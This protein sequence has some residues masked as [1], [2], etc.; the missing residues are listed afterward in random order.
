MYK[1]FFYVCFLLLLLGC[2]KEKFTSESEWIA[3]IFETNLSLADLIPDSLTRYNPDSSLILVFEEE[4]GISSLE[5]ILEIP[6]KIE[7]LEVNLSSLVLDDR[8]FN[9]TITLAE[10]YP[11]SIL[12]NGRNAELDAQDIQA[13]EGTVI[14]VT[15]QFFTEATFVEGWIDIEISNDLPVEAELLEFELRNDDDKS[16]V[17]SGTFENLAPNS[18]TKDSFDLSGKTVDG[19]LELIVKRVKTKASDGEVKVDAFKGLRIDFRVR[20]LKPKEATAIFPSQNLVERK[21]ETEYEFGGGDLTQIEIKTGAMYMKVVSTIE[22]EIILNYSFLRSYKRGSGSNDYIQNEW[23]IPPAPKG[24]ESQL[25]E[26]FPV[27]GY[28]IYLWGE[29]NLELPYTNHIYNELIASIEY[30]GVERTLSLEDKITIEFGLIDL[31]PKK[32]FGDPG[33]HELSFTDSLEINALDKFK[34]QISLEDANLN[35]DF[36]NS[37]GIQSELKINSLK[38]VNNRIPQTVELQ[39]SE[40]M[41]SILIDKV[42]NDS[43]STPFEKSISIGKNNS[44]LKQFLENIPDQ[45]LPDIDVTVRPNGTYQLTDFAFDYSQLKLDVQ[46]EVPLTIGLDSLTLQSSSDVSLFENEEVSQIKKATFTLKVDNDF[47]IEMVATL[48]F[49]DENGDVLLEG[50]DGVDNV[51]AQAEVDPTIGKTKSIQQSTLVMNLSQAEML[52]IQSA[53][54]IRTSFKMSTNESAR[55][56]MFADYSVSAKLKTKLT[57]ENQL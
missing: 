25:E 33:K 8:T 53:T 5:D 29:T 39:A 16:I 17:V 12:L 2:R 21:E 18:S 43:P 48:E 44:N 30:S 40:L 46:L 4:Y 36:Y 47:P 28:N 42:S 23:R 41:G 56:K 14:D 26:L 49:L 37:F 51:V 52:L 15:D 55:Y 22:E 45:I 11:P 9:D 3:P 57:Y 34:G 32:V 27:D 24:G 7:I 20:D 19:I 35:L 50:F 10:I 31:K 6:D 1:T 38:A 13:N 54:Q